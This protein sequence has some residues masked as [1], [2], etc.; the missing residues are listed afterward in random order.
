MSFFFDILPA[1]IAGLFAGASSAALPSTAG[2]ATAAGFTGTSL[3]AAGS[4]LAVGTGAAAAGGTIAGLTAGQAAE[5][6][7]TALS[8]ASTGLG[9]AASASAAAAERRAVGL[10]GDYAMQAAQAEA[11]SARRDDRRLA[12]RQRALYASGDVDVG[13]GSPLLTE[14]ETARQIGQRYSDR[15]YR[16]QVSRYSSRLMLPAIAAQ[17]KARVGSIAT[18]YFRSLLS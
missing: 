15:L 14:L 16:G 3:G 1:S 4:A 11:E 6:G 7:L 9:I 13:E 12:A 18:G 5:L 2:L 10:E 8:T 17:N